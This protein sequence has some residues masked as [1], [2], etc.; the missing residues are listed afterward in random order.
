MIESSFAAFFKSVLSWAAIPLM[1]LLSVLGFNFKRALDDLEALSIQ[2]QK[3]ELYIAKLEVELK[4]I[5]HDLQRLE[6]KK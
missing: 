4:Y 6:N 2:L 1:L 5:K 3:L